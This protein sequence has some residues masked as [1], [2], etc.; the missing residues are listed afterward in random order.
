MSSVEAN[1]TDYIKDNVITA[2]GTPSTPATELTAAQPATGIYKAI[3][4]GDADILDVL[5]SLATTKEVDGEDV[6]VPGEGLLGDMQLI[7]MDVTAIKNYIDTN[8]GTPATT[9]IVDNEEVVVPATGI[10][11]LI[12][13]NQTTLDNIAAW[14]GQ[15]ATDKKP[16][17]G[18]LGDIA[19]IQ[20]DVGDIKTDV[21][22]IETD[23][24]AIETDV[25]AIETDVADIETAIGTASTEDKVGTGLV[26]QLELLGVADEDIKTI[27]GAPATKEVVDDKEVAVPATGLY[28]AMQ[29]AASAATT[30]LAKATAV[31]NLTNLIGTPAT[32]KKVDGKDVEVPA[33]GIYVNS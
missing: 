12:G 17:T 1:V 9:K 4:D 3:E 11:A 5:G 24:A 29:Q 7:G 13:A 20:G 33:T 21:A 15:P 14:Y 6:E 8:L 28:L 18:L 25:A 16:A 2:I 26:R 31:T 27:I 30:D 19:T 22:A 23:V 10:F 32:T